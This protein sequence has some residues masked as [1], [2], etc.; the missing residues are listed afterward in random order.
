MS[1][2]RSN[3][4]NP[5]F[6]LMR[7]TSSSV[8]ANTTAMIPFANTFIS[9]NG[10]NRV[11]ATRVSVVEAG[12]YEIVI[13]IEVRAS[14]PSGFIIDSIQMGVNGVWT[15]LSTS[16]LINTA[17]G[18]LGNY[19]IIVNLAEGDYFELRSVTSTVPTAHTVYCNIGGGAS[20]VSTWIYPLYN[21]KK[22]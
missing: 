17:N 22:L 6:A 16:P 14:H 21:M 8:G 1:L 2:I 9:A 12:F 18:F 7:G 5:I 19:S 13:P 4:A 15:N 10:I 11:S 3:R 20:G